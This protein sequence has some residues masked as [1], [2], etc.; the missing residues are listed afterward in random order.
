MQPE[1]RRSLRE[2]RVVEGAQGKRLALPLLHVLAPLT[3]TLTYGPMD[4]GG[5]VAVR[6]TF[7]QRVLTSRTAAG[8]L[9]HLEYELL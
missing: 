3:T 2:Q 4:S 1:G 5:K 7:D 9:K 6:L 8:V